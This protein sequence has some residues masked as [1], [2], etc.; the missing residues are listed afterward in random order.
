LSVDAFVAHV[1]VGEPVTTSPGHA[2]RCA[3]PIRLDTRDAD[4]S[5][6][7]AAF[8]ATKREAAQDVEDAVKAIIADVVARGDAAL[9][10]L[11]KKFDRVDL[12]KVGLRV[13]PG[14]IAAATAACEP[15]A[16]ARC[17]TP[18]CDALQSQRRC[19]WWRPRSS[20]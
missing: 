4:F 19:C 1:L 11:S 20:S 12:A 13:A 6:R 17:R 3:M 2:Q 9:I 16:L 8:L 14:E 18:R 15:A 7:F 5:Q 10:E